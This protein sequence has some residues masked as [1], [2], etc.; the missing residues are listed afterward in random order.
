M[1]IL[2]NLLPEE[3]KE[4]IQGRLRSRFLLWQLFLLFL[5]EIFY[6]VILGS[7]YLI[8]DFQLRSLNTISESTAQVS[9][10]EASRL[11]TYE[12]QF[13]DINK[14]VDVIGKINYAHLYFSQVFTLVDPLVPDG[15][16]VNSLSTKEYVVSIFGK[17]ATRDQL[18][19]F[20]ENLKN[21]GSCISKVDIPIQ[22]LFSQENVDFQVNFSV[23]PE[24]LR[25]N[26]L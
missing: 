17:A 26:S 19:R 16:T 7:V 20:D 15:V 9:Q 3:R 12:Q 4:S 13:R 24:C 1:K 2:L 18:L 8:L 6:L 14:V 23:A 22:N 5:L 25:K 21:A 10:G 11:N